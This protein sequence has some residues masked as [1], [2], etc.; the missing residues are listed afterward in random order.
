MLEVNSKS[1]GQT[2]LVT[3]RQVQELELQLRDIVKD[4]KSDNAELK[5]KVYQ[6]KLNLVDYESVRANLESRK[7]WLKE[8]KEKNS[9]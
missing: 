8:Y 4:I 7:N 9:N 2:K 5:R 3:Q 1:T 6:L